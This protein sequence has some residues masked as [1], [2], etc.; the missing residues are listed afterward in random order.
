M[1]WN[2][3]QTYQNKLFSRNSF[4]WDEYSHCSHLVFQKKSSKWI[5]TTISRKNMILL[6]SLFYQCNYHN[7]LFIHFSLHLVRLLYLFWMKLLQV[8]FQGSI[9]LEILVTLLTLKI[10][11]VSVFIC[12]VVVQLPIQIKSHFTQVTFQCLK[13]FMNIGLLVLWTWILCYIFHT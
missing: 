5:Q 12:N 3:Y 9:I 4:K 7:A 13:I 2:T 10:V 1:I 11:F 6:C 8:I